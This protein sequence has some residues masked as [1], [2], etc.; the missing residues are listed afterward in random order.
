MVEQVDRNVRML[1]TNELCSSV[2]KGLAVLSK[3][4]AFEAGSSEDCRKV[5]KNSFARG[6]DPKRV[7][8]TG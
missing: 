5:C 4:Q 1:R 6:G 3:R 7:N 8:K 2:V